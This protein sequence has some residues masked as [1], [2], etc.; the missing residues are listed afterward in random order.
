MLLLLIAPFTPRAAV[1][2]DP[3]EIDAMNT[4]R[5]QPPKDGTFHDRL[6][7]DDRVRLSRAGHDIVADTVLRALAAAR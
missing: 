4:L 1:A 5:F 3:Q 2:D 6:Y 7:V